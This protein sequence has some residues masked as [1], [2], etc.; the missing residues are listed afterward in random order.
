MI[1]EEKADVLL[2]MDLCLELWSDKPRNPT[3]ERNVTEGTADDDGLGDWA[4]TRGG[5]S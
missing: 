4:A 3:E 2:R 1:L 5:R